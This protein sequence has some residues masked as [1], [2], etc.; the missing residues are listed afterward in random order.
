MAWPGPR[1]PFRTVRRR[2]WISTAT[3]ALVGAVPAVGCAGY[4]PAPIEP[5]ATLATVE[6]RSLEAP[7]LGGFLR[8]RHVVSDWPPS[9]WGLDLLTLAAF[10]YSPALDVARARWAVSRAGVITAGG[11]ANPTLS[12][13][14][15][16]NA[17][18]PSDQVTPWI[19]EAALELPVDLAGKR[20]IRISRARELSEAARF[21]VLTAA[22]E[23]RS[24]VRKAFLELSLARESDSL[25]TLQQR[26][27]AESVT[28][29]EAQQRLGEISPNEVTQS[30]LALAR[31]RLAAAD[32]SERR[33]RARSALAEAIG[34]DPSALDS[35]RLSPL[36]LMSVPPELPTREI[37][38]RALVNRSDVRA[39]LAEYEASQ[40]ALRL[41]IRK[42]YPDLS[43]GP[44][45]Q[46]DQTDSKW[47]LR[48]SLPIPLGNRN[49]GPIAEATARR[50]E[51]AARFL[52]LQSKVLA[53][54]EGAVASTRLVIGQTA[55]ADTLLEGL[56]RQERSAE[57]AYRAGQISRLELLGVQT[58]LVNSALVRLDGLRRAEEAI[59][60]LEDAMQS[61]L[62][63]QDWTLSSPGRG[64]RSGPTKGAWP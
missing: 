56:R 19:P 14:L 13:G 45:Y 26:L 21:G 2:R 64:E 62:E 31:S 34:V 38:R 33:I 40:Q 50:E 39:A 53:E 27:Q 1:S 47:T 35:V 17:S 6:S 8:A 12:G 61:P 54:L 55:A 43:L 11:R 22:W 48:L 10:Y 51:A 24:R 15:G 52:S 30:R 18:T 16:Y 3:V 5:G 36:E 4:R 9:S 57:G 44:G 42:Q 58:E 28:I 29:L 59:G 25:L 7:A 60:A 46:L 32:V 20:G 49:R 23:V 63:V 37:R 41:E